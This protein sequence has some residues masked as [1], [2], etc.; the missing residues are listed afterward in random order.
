[1]D[2]QVVGGQ[3]AAAAFALN[4]QRAPAN[5]ALALSLLDPNHPSLTPEV[6]LSLAQQGGPLSAEAIRTLTLRTAGG[7][8]IEA[9]ARLA[10]DP[11]LDEALRADAVMGLAMDA[12]SQ[13]PRL[14][15]LAADA[16]APQ[17]QQEAARV[18]A[19]LTEKPHAAGRPELNDLGAWLTR[20][21][22]GGQ[23]AA[24]W[25][26]FFRA[27]AGQ[28]A[29][30]HAYQG[31]GARVG[32]DLSTLAG[33]QPRSRILESILDPHREIGPLYVPW[34][35]VTVDGRVLTGLKLH[36]PGI[37]DQL[38]FLASDGT[39]FDVELEEIDEQR[40]ISKSIM[41]DGLWQGL[42]DDELRD[43][44]ALLSNTE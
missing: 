5:R 9:L 4:P 29:T 40:M 18:L 39:T 14:E 32:P 36:E 41:P 44:L 12:E 16:A 26:V 2:R 42:S 17:V 7:A 3:T 20:V 15:R 31:R 27:G 33:Q 1:V 21:G 34:Q 38:R 8:G 19:R 6:L 25:R 10:D 11:A 13:R 23:P 28:C 37:G 35:I 22:E 43:L 30:C 24:G